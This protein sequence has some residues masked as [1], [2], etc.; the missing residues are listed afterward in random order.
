MLKVGKEASQP[1]EP[2]GGDEQQ[3][4]KVQRRRQVQVQIQEIE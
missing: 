4:E 1:D 3:Q 2:T